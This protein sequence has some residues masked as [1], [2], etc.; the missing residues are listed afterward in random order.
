MS[1][2]PAHVAD[3]APKEKIQVEPSP[4][5]PQ[6]LSWLEGLFFGSGDYPQKL[7]VR[8][9]WGSRHERG[10]P[11]I[12]QIVFPPNMIS[13]SDRVDTE[14]KAESGPGGK[15]ERRKHKPNRE[16]LVEVSH[17]I[18]NRIQLECDAAGKAGVYF[19]LAT[20]LAVSD[21][22]YERFP[23]RAAPKGPRLERSEDD[24][25]EEEGVNGTKSMNKAFLLGMEQNKQMFQL[26]GS[27]VEGMV[28]RS[29]R[30]LVRAEEALEATR[31]Q[32]LRQQDVVSR[33]MDIQSEREMKSDMHK[34]K[35]KVMDRGL[36][37]F[38]GFAPQFLPGLLGGK[39]ANG[40]VES[41]ES[42]ILKTFLRPIEEGG[43]LTEGQ[44]DQV[45]GMFD[46]SPEM[47]LVKPGAL[48]E[49]QGRIIHGVAHLKMPADEL[50]KLVPGGACALTQDQLV[51]LRGVFSDSLDQIAPIIGLMGMIMQ[52]VQI[53]NAKGKS[54]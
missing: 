43:Q 42:M 22:P 46:D 35:I 31:T 4:R 54:E 16:E 17:D 45:F 37:M 2:S 20:H 13:P 24:E 26:L 10:G 39:G 15:S 11:V 12:K 51:S 23:I 48:T 40:I 32:L 28:D 29:D 49:E 47:K 38:E 34:F 18:L 3:R 19:I 6:L 33:A 25:D 8:L 27:M 41:S 30:A 36:N 9:M 21:Q 44:V 50:E 52:K 1:E 14:D 53:R 5:N 7:E